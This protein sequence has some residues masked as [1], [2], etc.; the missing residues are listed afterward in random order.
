MNRLYPLAL[1]A[2]LLLTSNARAQHLLAESH[3]LAVKPPEVNDSTYQPA[4]QLSMPVAIDDTSASSGQQLANGI[5]TG[6]LASVDAAQG[7]RA[8]RTIVRRPTEN[9]VV[10][11]VLGL[12]FTFGLVGTVVVCGGEKRAR[13]HQLF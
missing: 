13:P 11:S 7:R 12:T 6:D 8:A 1:L 9:W 2:S 10:V 3:P 5:L 4:R